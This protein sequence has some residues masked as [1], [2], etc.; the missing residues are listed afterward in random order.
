MLMPAAEGCTCQALG[1]GAQRGPKCFISLRRSHG[2]QM[3]KQT[4]SPAGPPSWSGGTGGR[5]RLS[6][7][8]A[9]RRGERLGS[10]G[11]GPP[12]QQGLGMGF[13]GLGM[14]PGLGM[15]VWGGGLAEL[16]PYQG[17]HLGC[18]HP[19]LTLTEVGVRGPSSCA[20]LVTGDPWWAGPV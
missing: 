19:H 5:P 16:L 4:P 7:G 13:G 15:P 12:P 17:V 14:A 3:V 10:H 2:E 18:T 11:L 20:Q 8:T 9:P 6:D 1:G